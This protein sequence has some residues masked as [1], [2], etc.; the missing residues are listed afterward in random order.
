MA[1]ANVGICT[2]SMLTFR[3][4]NWNWTWILVVIMHLR[5]FS[6]VIWWHPTVLTIPFTSVITVVRNCQLSYKNANS[7][8]F[9]KL[10]I[11][12]LQ[13]FSSAWMGV[14]HF[15]FFHGKWISGQSKMDTK[16]QNQSSFHLAD[17]CK[18]DFEIES[19]LTKKTWKLVNSTVMKP[20]KNWVS[21]THK[22]PWILKG[23]L[24]SRF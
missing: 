23:K 9:V 10:K 5:S 16:R 21:Q 24:I 12:Y 18:S 22:I 3:I 15:Q 2:I 20:F 1:C 19:A 4:T 6:L 14:I 11:Q 7:Q 13:V 17:L 8:L